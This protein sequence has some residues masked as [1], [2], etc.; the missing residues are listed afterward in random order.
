MKKRMQEMIESAVI[1][2]KHF[3]HVFTLKNGED[4]LD[5][6]D[7]LEHRQVQMVIHL[8]EPNH[9]G[10]QAIDGCLQ[11]I[12]KEYSHVKFC[13]I[14]ASNAGL[15]RNFKVSFFIFSTFAWQVIVSGCSKK[16]GQLSIL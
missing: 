6:V 10:C 12:A 16:Y 4:F 15:S 11:T 13:R 7:D 9:P 14:Q 1:N 3:G 8:F 2:K 5:A